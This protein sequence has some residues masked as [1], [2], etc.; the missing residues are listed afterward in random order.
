MI[1]EQFI[2]VNPAR[3]MDFTRRTQLDREPQGSERTKDQSDFR[4]G[5]SFFQSDDRIPTNTSLVGQ[6]R[7]AEAEPLSLR[8]HR[9]RQFP[10]V[11]YPHLSK[12]SVSANDD[13]LKMRSIGNNL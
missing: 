8:P 10:H 13:K 11:S 3:R 6:C 1:A 4:R 9:S 12:A 5:F 2:E 7:L